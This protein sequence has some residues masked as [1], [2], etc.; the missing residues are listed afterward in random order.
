MHAWIP[1]HFPEDA[2][3][4][5]R[6]AEHGRH[7]MVEYCVRRGAA[8]VLVNKAVYGA[9]RKKHPVLAAYPARNP[10]LVND[11]WLAR[12]RMS[13][14]VAARNPCRVPPWEEGWQ[15]L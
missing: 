5:P 2:G 4:K 7:R 1:G 14:D 13:R 15:D 3:Y 11:S 10:G 12:D 8:A 6:K 9:G